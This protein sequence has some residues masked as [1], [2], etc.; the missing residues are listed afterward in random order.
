MYK[1]SDKGYLEHHNI[2]QTNE[3]REEKENVHKNHKAQKTEGRGRR[4]DN[5]RSRAH[6]GSDRDS[7]QAHGHGGI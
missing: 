1:P 5:M 7:V 3:K 6:C 4:G 2:T